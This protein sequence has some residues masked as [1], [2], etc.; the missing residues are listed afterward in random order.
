LIKEG[1][2]VLL[3]GKRRFVVK[4]SEGITKIGKGT[5]DLSRI[6]GMEYGDE[7]NLWG[8]SYRIYRPSRKDIVESMERG[9]QV[10]LPKDA[11][12]ITYLCDIRSG[13]TV[14]EAGSGSGWLTSALALSVMPYGKVISYDKSEKSLKTAMKNIENAGLEEY[15]EFRNGDIRNA[16]IG[17][18]IDACVLDM[19][20]PWNAFDNIRRYMV[21]G[22]HICVYVPTYNQVEESVLNMKNDFFDIS[23]SETILRSIDVKEGATR[24]AF[25]GLMHTGFI[26][27]GRKK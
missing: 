24:P 21:S 20:D 14:L 16:D 25:N 26:V 18:R 12:Q 1:D 8:E 3:L 2:T 6:V 11:A 15:V 17:E 5:V 13:D 7:I 27:H 22:S 10:V 4:V 23:A 19:P 9:A